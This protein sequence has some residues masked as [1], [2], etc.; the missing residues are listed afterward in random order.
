MLRVLKS[1]PN[2][3]AADAAFTSFSRHLWFFSEQL[4]GL[5][6]FDSRVKPEVKRAMGANLQLPK[7]PSALKRVNATDV[8]FNRLETFV[9]KRT[10]QLFELLSITGKEEANNFLPKDPE[11]WEADASYQKLKDRVQKTKVV[12]DSTEHGIALIEKYNEC[13][14]RDEEQKQYLLHFVQH[15]RQLYPTSS[16]AVMLDN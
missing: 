14:T 16:R 12:N 4:V 2:C 6:F 5:A 11:S 9:T 10:N 13:L 8:D 3:L 15:H 1:Y 7:S